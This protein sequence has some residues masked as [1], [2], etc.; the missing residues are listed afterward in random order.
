MNS[1]FIGLLTGPVLLCALIPTTSFADPV[2]PNG[3]FLPQLTNGLVG[4]GNSHFQNG[5]SL[6]DDVLTFDNGVSKG[7]VITTV[8]TQPGFNAT[9]SVNGQGLMAAYANGGYYFQ[10]ATTEHVLVSGSGGVSN[11]ISTPNQVGISIGGPS[12]S[13]SLGDACGST[14]GGCG[15]IQQS[16]FSFNTP[17]TLQAGVTYNIQ[18]YLFADANTLVI[19]GGVDSQFAFVDPIISFDPAF[20]DGSNFHLFFSPT[21]GNTP[22]SAIPEPS[23]WAMMIL[24]FAGVGF[25]AYRRKSKSALMAA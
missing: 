15:S 22:T 20:S 2:L 7:T 6:S 18:M 3:F 23:T 8:S 19:G 11:A 13:I 24:G 4:S 10:S 1:K 5:P 12:G 14:H 9:V 17:F 21:V 25:M 16:S